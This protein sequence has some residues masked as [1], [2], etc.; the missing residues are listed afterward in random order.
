MK[1]P[2]N[3]SSIETR[4]RWWKLQTRHQG[5]RQRRHLLEVLGVPLLFPTSNSST[6]NFASTP[7]L[8]GVCISL[9]LSLSLSLYLIALWFDFMGSDFHFSWYFFFLFF[10]FFYFIFNLIFFFFLRKSLV[11]CFFFFSG[12]YILE[13]ITQIYFIYVLSLWFF[14]FLPN[15]AYHFFSFLFVY[16]ILFFIILCLN[17]RILNIRALSVIDLLLIFITDSTTDPDFEEFYITEIP[18][19]CSKNFLLVK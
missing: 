10:Y 14:F 19:K 12:V 3:K 1:T 7:T 8:H 15:F 2:Q 18:M 11:V 5:Q 6:S 17:T 9:S 13:S 16:L 4:R